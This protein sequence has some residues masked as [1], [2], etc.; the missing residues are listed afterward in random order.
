MHEQLQFQALLDRINMAYDALGHRM[1]WSL[2]YTPKSTLHASQQLL[3]LGLNPGGK[4]DQR[5]DAVPSCESGNEYLHGKWVAEVGK[6]ALQFQ[7]QQLFKRIAL[8]TGGNINHEYMMDAT[9]AANF[10]PF[11][12]PNW[13]KLVN[14]Q[15]TMEFSRSLWSEILDQLHP[16]VI[17]CIAYLVYDSIKTILVSKG[18]TP[19]DTDKAQPIGWGKVTYNMTELRNDDRDILLVRLPHLSTYKVFSSA[20]CEM[21]IKKLTDRIASVLDKNDFISEI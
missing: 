2:L 15:K 12:S 10:V 6:A 5:Y 17:I 21:E 13:T 14:K 11:R 18:F 4:E 16:R 3:F 7:V 19:I 20:K 8:S 1:G 9:L